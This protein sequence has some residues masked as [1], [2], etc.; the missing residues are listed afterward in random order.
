MNK[1]KYITAVLIALVGLGLQQAK[2]T[3]FQPSTFTSQL[4]TGPNNTTGNFGTVVV[5]LTSPTTATITFTSNT[6]NNFFFIDTNA[7]N[8]QVNATSFTE[9]IGT[10][11]AFKEFQFGNTVNGFNTFN[12]NVINNDG[13]A[14]KVS[15]I[16]FTVTDTS[17]TFTNASTVL[18]LNA[19][20]F[21]AAAHVIDEN[22]AA[23]PPT[24][25]VAEVPGV[26]VP[27]GGTTAM[28][29]GAALSALGLVGRFVKR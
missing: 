4:N 22:G 12:L 24:F 2:A 20:G 13:A 8:V 23:S 15:T 21:D 28:L 10:D 29:L 25:F 19:G 1:V 7:A 11:T 3:V 14:D 16:S 17:G 5:V 9:A 27:D 6:A 26:F 18:A